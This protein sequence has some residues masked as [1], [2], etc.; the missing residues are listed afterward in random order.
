M[1]FKRIIEEVVVD[2][3]DG[4]I[5]YFEPIPGQQIRLAVVDDPQ[6]GH[7]QIRLAGDADSLRR[8]GEILIAMSNAKD[9][10]VLLEC[11]SP[12]PLVVQPDHTCLVIEKTDC[13]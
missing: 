7:Q 13:E 6:N 12:T 5:P 3:T 1:D 11:E 2:L 4:G 8:L 10:H 9:C